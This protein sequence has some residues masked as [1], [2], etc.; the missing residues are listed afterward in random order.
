MGRSEGGRVKGSGCAVDGFLFAHSCQ[1][2]GS[3]KGRA[4]GRRGVL[5]CCR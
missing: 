2:E 5:R 3:M 1:W 4:G